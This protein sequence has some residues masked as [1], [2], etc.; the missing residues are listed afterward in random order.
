MPKLTIIVVRE[1]KRVDRVDRVN[2]KRAKAM[3]KGGRSRSLKSNSLY[4]NKD[5][6]RRVLDIP[7]PL[8][9]PKSLIVL[10]FSLPLYFTIAG[11]NKIRRLVY[12]YTSLLVLRL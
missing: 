11:L 8:F 7:S 6:S 12:G 9:L 10:P 2:Y 4:S 1:V 5:R 3:L